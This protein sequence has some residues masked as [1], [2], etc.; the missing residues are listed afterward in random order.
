MQFHSPEISDVK[1]GKKLHH[2][3]KEKKGLNSVKMPGW[4]RFRLYRKKDAGKYK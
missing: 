2:V 3:K 1:E 4:T